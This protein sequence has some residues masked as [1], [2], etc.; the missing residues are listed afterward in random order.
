MRKKV[1]FIMYHYPL[2]VSSMI[3]NSAKMFARNG[4]GVDIYIDRDTFNASPASFN[5]D[6]IK[7]IF[8]EKRFRY[9]MH[10][11]S[12]FRFILYINL[13]RGLIKRYHSYIPS[14]F[15]HL[16]YLEDYLFSLWLRKRID[17]DYDYIFPVEATALISTNG[18]KGRIIYYN[19]EILDWSERSPIYGRDKIFLKILES[20]A[21]K[22]ANAAVI[23]N[24]N[25]AEEFRKI[26]SFSKETY[27][28]PVAAMDDPIIYGTDSRLREKFG[29]SDKTK[30]VIYSGNIMPWAKCLE[31]VESV[32]KWPDGFCLVLHTWR[33]GVFESDEYGRTVKEAAKGLPVF[34]SDNYLDIEDLPGYLSSADVSLMFY[35][36]IDANFIEI[37]F[38]SNKLAEYLKA[39]LPVITSDVPALRKFVEENGIGFAIGSMDEL[40]H[41]LLEISSRQESFHKNVIACYQNRFRFEN[42]FMPFFEKLYPESGSLKANER[43]KKI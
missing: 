5:E 35:E 43:G 17:D 15:I 20:R 23:Q 42:F 6:N 12:V 34:F 28:L 41:S 39:A 11:Y 13:L 38:S 14:V 1:A 31:V 22:G 9:L 29:I 26:N 2:G 7:I 19:M 10:L 27:I 37:L 24:E 40:P 32:K 3:L 25:R 16:Y 36:A 18:I 4:I 21:L 30:I 33:K 8:Y